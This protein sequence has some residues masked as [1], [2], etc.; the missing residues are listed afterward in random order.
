M[1]HTARCR[2][3]NERAHREDNERRTRLGAT[4]RR[5][6]GESRQSSE[7]SG[8]EKLAGRGSINNPKM[9]VFEERST[10]E[11]VQERVRD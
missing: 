2:V 7:R 5:F 1:P 9:L 3:R 10:L 11:R 8:R 4:E 6:F